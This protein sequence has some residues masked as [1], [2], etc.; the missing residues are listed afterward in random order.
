[1]IIMC[2]RIRYYL[3]VIPYISG[4]FH[5]ILVSKYFM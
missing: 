2:S 5:N 4:N 3:A 1:M